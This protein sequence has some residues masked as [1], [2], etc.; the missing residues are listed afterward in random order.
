MK[1]EYDFKGAERGKFHVK[2]AVLVPPVHLE[3]DVLTYLA[4]R[5]EARGATLSDLVNG[6]L[7]ADIALIEAAG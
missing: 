2:D 6:L 5:A 4:A 7:R 3:A 1:D